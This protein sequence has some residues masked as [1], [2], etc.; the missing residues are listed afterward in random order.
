MLEINNNLPE[1]SVSK[2]SKVSLGDIVDLTVEGNQVVVVKSKGISPIGFVTRLYT[3][4][5]LP[6]N[7]MT[8]REFITA[9]VEFR[10]ITGRTD[11]YETNQLYPI[12]AN[13]YVSEAGELT[14]RR[15]SPVHPVVAM[16]IQGLS[17]MNSVL[18]FMWL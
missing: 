9:S 4:L 8:N 2:N 18:H 6:E 15:P 3:D 10:K 16:V 14:T 1:F 5:S 17:P 11:L 12:S 13:L 7:S